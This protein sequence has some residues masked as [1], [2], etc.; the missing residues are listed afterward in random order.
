MSVIASVIRFI[1]FISTFGHM[2]SFCPLLDRESNNYTKG[3]EVQ[4]GTHRDLPVPIL[5]K[6]IY[7]RSTNRTT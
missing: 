7:A 4:G 5:E 3:E 2:G 1:E 6:P